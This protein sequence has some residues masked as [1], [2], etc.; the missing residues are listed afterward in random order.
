MKLGI[1]YMVSLRCKMVVKA[2]LD[3]LGLH[4]RSIDLGEVDL[5][6]HEITVEQ[7]DRLRA[8]LSRSGLELMEDERSMLVEKIKNIVDEIIADEDELIQTNISTYLSDR[9]GHE[10]AFLA[11][12]FSEVTGTTISLYI[13][14]KKIEKAKELI[15]YHEFN[16]TEIAYKL[17]YSSVAHLSGQFKKLTGLTPTYFKNHPAVKRRRVPE[18]S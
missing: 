18:T 10:Y 14:N 9:L 12:I 4:S 2:A 3:E 17:H 8:I 1:K 15:L 11:G 5:F 13:L 6:E 7:H 16:L